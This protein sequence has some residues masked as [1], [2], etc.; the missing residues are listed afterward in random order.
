MNY[1]NVCDEPKNELH[2]CEVCS[3]DT[4]Y[5]CL[6]DLTYQNMIDFNCCKNCEKFNEI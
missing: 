4:C 1:C 5:E 2:T 6:V 3:Q